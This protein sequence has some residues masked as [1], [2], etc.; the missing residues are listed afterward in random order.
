MIFATNQVRHVLVQNSDTDGP[1]FVLPEDA[2]GNIIIHD[3][4]FKVVQTAADGTFISASDSI[5]LDKIIS[6]TGEL[7]KS[8]FKVYTADATDWTSEGSDVA[9]L[10]VNIY[11]GPGSVNFVT[12]YIPYNNGNPNV[13][14]LGLVWEEN[15]E[16]TGSVT[17]TFR[18]LSQQELSSTAS[19][20]SGIIYFSVS[21]V[22]ADLKV[23]D[24]AVT[25]SAGT[26]L[27]GYTVKQLEEF[28]NSFKGS[29]DFGVGYPYCSE[30]LPTYADPNMGYEMLNIHYYYE[31]SNES[32]QKSEK[33]LTLCTLSSNNN[34][35]E[36]LWDVLAN[37]PHV[38]VIGDLSFPT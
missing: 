33:D 1:V 5:E 27:R 23:L 15:T 36:S 4:S 9:Y 10:K 34:V 28:C 25:E 12:H 26:T 3:N 32:V 19:G 21:F 29:M 7:S 24:I 38:K 22:D 14:K 17:T 20:K 8:P 6:I 2:Q 37:L 16:T 35:V 11:E 13:A 31:G 30:A 18:T